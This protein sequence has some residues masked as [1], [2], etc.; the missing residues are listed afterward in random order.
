MTKNLLFKIT[1]LDPA[2]V[3][4]I[5]FDIPN[6]GVAGVSNVALS[7]TS[8]G[9]VVV[10]GTRVTVCQ[11]KLQLQLTTYSTCS[12]LHKYSGFSPNSAG[13]SVP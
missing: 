5:T 4:D 10:N 13:S 12:I 9:D 3:T 11:G 1:N 2:S 8:T 6:E 7:F